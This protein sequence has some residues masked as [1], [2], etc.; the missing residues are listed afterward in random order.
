M[1]NEQNICPERFDQN[2]QGKANGLSAAVITLGCKVNQCEG[3]S[4]TELFE[5]AGYTIK[6]FSQ[7]ADVYIINTCSV[8]AMAESKSRKLIHRAHALNGDALII[9]T[10][11]YSQRAGNE[12]LNLP[13]VKIVSGNAGKSRLTELA[14]EY[15]RTERPIQGVSDIFL[16]RDF[17][18]MP[19]SRHDS[20]TRGYIKIQDGCENYC[21]YCIIPYLRG[22]SRSRALKDIISEG[23]RLADLGYK[24]LV[25]GG[26]QLSAYGLD[27]PGSPRLT[28]VIEAL[29]QIEG[30]SRI[31]LGSLEPLLIEEEFAK[32]LSEFDALCPQFHLSLQSGSDSVLKRMNRKYDTA[33]YEQAVSYLRR[34]LDNP[35]ITTDII[36]GFPAETQEEFEQTRAFIHKIGFASV[37][38][39]AYSRREGTAA[40]QMNGQV[41]SEIKKE[42]S[43]ILIEQAQRDAANYCQS[44]ENAV[45]PVL[46]ETFDGNTLKGLTPEHLEVSVISQR[47]LTGE[48]RNVRLKA[49]RG[50]L[51]GMLEV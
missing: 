42:R 40:A 25:L 9:I 29:S 34:Y 49:E 38:V 47:D 51:T 10:G 28:D 18:E 43:R 23:R 46:F 41:N 48:I 24:E 14:E 45:R 44:F 4:I 7:P 12:L 26:I 13:G 32:R 5:K 30:I 8:T 50:R 1:N 16:Q 22:P 36:T 20:R 19:L 27:L 2:I 21:A 17:E 31:R 6:P 3:Q 37:H 35:A 11:C 33:R 39:F 15:F